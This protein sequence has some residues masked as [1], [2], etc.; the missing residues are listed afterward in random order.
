MALYYSSFLFIPA[1]LFALM[2]PELPR[3]NA[4]VDAK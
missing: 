3:G 4:A 1:A 2:L